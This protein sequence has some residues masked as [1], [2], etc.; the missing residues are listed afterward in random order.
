V[1]LPRMR[2]TVRWMMVVVGL[3]AL[4]LGLHQW[5]GVLRRRAAHFDFVAKAY[6][7]EATNH[8]ASVVFYA[9]LRE[10]RG[11]PEAARTAGYQDAPLFLNDWGGRLTVARQHEHDPEAI[12]ERD[13][14]DA[15]DVV[16][17]RSL[18]ARERARAKFF[19]MLAGKYGHA[20]RYPWLS[21]EADPLPP[22]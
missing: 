18:E 3:V 10:R 6:Q 2:F 14:D 21:I 9:T 19:S 4:G 22:E 7:L 1:R 5:I 15:R 17:L 8:E 20:A 16:R 13:P 11:R 12:L